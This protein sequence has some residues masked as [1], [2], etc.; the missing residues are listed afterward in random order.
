MHT[1][2]PLINSEDDQLGRFPFATQIASGLVNSFGNNN[3]SIVL[4]INGTWGTG[5]STLIN[6]IVQEVERISLEQEKHAITL[7]FNPWMFSGQQELQKIFLSKLFVKLG[8]DKTLL[9][10]ASEKIADILEYFDWIKN[11]HSGAGTLVSALKGIFKKRAGKK[12]ELSELKK[13][14]D[15]LLIKAGVKLYITI[16]DIDRLTPSEITDIFQM[17]KLNGNFANT[18]FIL[19]Y[20]RDVVTAALNEQF[21]DHGEKYIEKIVQVDYTLPAVSDENIKRIFAD[22]LLQLFSDGDVKQTLSEVINSLKEELFVEFFSSIRDIYRF[23]NSIKLRFASVYND[24][25]V[26]EFFIVEALRIFNPKAYEFIIENKGLLIYKK[27]DSVVKTYRFNNNNVEE[28][29]VN[30]VIEGTSFDPTTKGLLSRLFEVNGHFFSS[31][32][33]ED[34][35]RGKRVAN[36]NYFDRYFNLQLGNLDIQE[37]IFDKFINSTDTEVKVEILSEIHNN[38]RL[39][40]F[41]RWIEIKSKSSDISQI[42]EIMFGCFTFSESLTYT[43][44]SIFAFDSDFMT[45]QRF[46][47]RML[48]R[49]YEVSERKRVILRHITDQEK[50]YSFSSFFTSDSLILAKDRKDKGELRQDHM[51]N[52]LFLDNR[53]DKDNAFIEKANEVRKEAIKAVFLEEVEDKGGLGEDELFSILRFT[54][55]YFSDLY[56][57]HFPSFIVEDKDLVRLI[58]I[59]MKSSYFTIAGGGKSSIGYQLNDNQLLSGLDKQAIKE[60]FDA[61]DRLLIDEDENKVVN[62]FL[63]AYE[64]NFV[65][66]RYYDIETLEILQQK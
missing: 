13:E 30:S 55:M 32:S 48:S 39:F 59:C 44:E 66:N 46:C 57:E 56:D 52:D 41:L 8:N 5:K 29:T 20:D 27:D 22:S 19:A 64:D 51:W 45:V 34:L 35:I 60:R 17:V 14:V 43:K 3:D 23:T 62:L 6:F 11:F 33:Q 7:H 24:L 58:W 4:G 63:K 37:A 18:I 49:F 10:E 9:K 16:D 31:T 2:L 50:D 54:K 15:N 47:S 12:K 25:N 21:G 26:S 28:E 42:E 61:F 53:E 40:Q 1:D 65:M 38:D 36:K